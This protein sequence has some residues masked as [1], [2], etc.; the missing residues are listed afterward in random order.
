MRHS[1][2]ALPGARL[3]LLLAATANLATAA[4][5]AHA[6][7]PRLDSRDLDS[8]HC[9]LWVQWRGNSVYQGQGGQSVVTDGMEVWTLGRPDRKYRQLGYVIYF[10][11]YGDAMFPKNCPD[12]AHDA[13]ALQVAK[14]MGADAMIPLGRTNNKLQFRMIKY[15]P[16]DDR[17]PTTDDDVPPDFDNRAAVKE[18]K[19]ESATV[20]ALRFSRQAP[21]AT[22]YPD[23]LRRQGVSGSVVVSICPDADGIAAS[24]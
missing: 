10:L 1:S 21:L 3:L 22:Y 7:T 2:P 6:G 12:Q 20:M 24:R 9:V 5:F 15:V 18:E 14:D 4:R 11:P 23:D 19:Y 8:Q 13:D 17:T 16:D